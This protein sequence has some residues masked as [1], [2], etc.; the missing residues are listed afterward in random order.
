M[1]S[2]AS[3]TRERSCRNE[4]GHR[5]RKPTEETSQPECTKSEQK[6]Q[7]SPENVA[8]LAIEKLE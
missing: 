8:E 1:E 4:L 7:L 2:T 3:N 6:E 5:S